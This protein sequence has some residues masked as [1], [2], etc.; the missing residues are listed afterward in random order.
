VIAVLVQAAGL[1][2]LPAAVFCGGVWAMSRLPGRDH[3]ARRL[4]EL[5]DPA[6]RKPLNRRFGY[7]GR[8]VRRHWGALDDRA[9]RAER[10]LLR[11]DLAFPLAYGAAFAVSLVMA[12]EALGRPHSAAWP[13]LPVALA[14]LADWTEN[15]V[16][17]GQLGRFV[18]GGDDAL[19][20][21]WIRVASTATAVKLLASGMTSVVLVVLVVAMVVRP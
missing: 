19:Q 11:L 3:V 6:D 13:L 2:A 14:M 9:L 20:P 8:A 5:P 4:S 10:H 18:D 21:S 1:L 7:G 16:Q 17:L 15:L 12:W